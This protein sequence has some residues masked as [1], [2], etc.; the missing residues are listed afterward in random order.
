MDFFPKKM[1]VLIVYPFYLSYNLYTLQKEKK[2]IFLGI[3]MLW[4]SWWYY[5]GQ[6]WA[7]QFTLKCYSK[8]SRGGFSS[9]LLFPEHF[10]CSW[11]VFIGGH[12]IQNG[13]GKLE[14]GAGSRPVTHIFFLT[15]PPY[16]LLIANQVIS[17]ASITCTKPSARTVK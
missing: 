6:L 5:C 16:P 7:V 1:I 10:Y 4:M 13:F 15:W 3:W 9:L 2:K 12:Y 11:G 8:W 14:L 17:H